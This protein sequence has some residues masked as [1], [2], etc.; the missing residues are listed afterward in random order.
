MHLIRK[1]TATLIL[2]TIAGTGVAAN[3]FTFT[4]VNT[5]PGCMIRPAQ[6]SGLSSGPLAMDGGRHQYTLTSNE[7]SNPQ[8]LNVNFK[9]D[10][11]CS[12]FQDAQA[13]S[14]SQ[15]TSPKGGTFPPTCYVKFTSDGSGSLS[16]S[17][18]MYMSEKSSCS[19]DGHTVTVNMVGS[20]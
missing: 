4:V 20:G 17:T 18:V 14:H 6:Y 8:E 15:P 10:K 16:L 2:A 13:I 19:V 9:I 3:A 1:I 11:S 12:W 7:V 5:S